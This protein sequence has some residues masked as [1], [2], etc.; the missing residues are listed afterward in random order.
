MAGSAQSDELVAMTL[1]RMH[2]RQLALMALAFFALVVVPLSAVFDGSTPAAATPTAVAGSPTK[3]HIGPG[4]AV[5]TFHHG[6]LTLR[7]QVE[8][9]RARARNVVSLRLTQGGQP[10][11]GA[12]VNVTYGMPAMDMG[13]GLSNVLP[14]RSSG[15]YSLREPILGMAGLWTLRF[16]VRTPQAGSFKVTA[17][18]IL[19]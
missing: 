18:D 14:P 6:A 7:L 8:P 13:N 11:H 19:H 4:P 12:R 3:V 1:Q 17:D 10:V 9:N 5:T 2:P 15:T 16:D